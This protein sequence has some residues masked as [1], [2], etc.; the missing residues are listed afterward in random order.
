VRSF[1]GLPGQC[2]LFLICPASALV[3]FWVLARPVRSFFWVCPASALFFGFARQARSFLGLP[4]QP[5]RSFLG[6]PGQYVLF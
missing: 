2:A 6:L 1:L 5:V 4:G 3:L